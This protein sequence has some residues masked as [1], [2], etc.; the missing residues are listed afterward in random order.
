MVSIRC[1]LR[2]KP[3]SKE[4]KPV[5]ENGIKKDMRSPKPTSKEWKR[6]L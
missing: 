2:P 4:W 6:S 5:K 1:T 3:T